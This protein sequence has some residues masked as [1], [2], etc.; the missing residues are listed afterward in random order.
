M[1]HLIAP[2]ETYHVVDSMPLQICRL[3]GLDEVVFVVMTLIQPQI[4][5]IATHK[6]CIILVT[7]S[8]WLAQYKVY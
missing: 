2:N 4:M 6:K 5:G 8:M 7:N 3:V 1:G